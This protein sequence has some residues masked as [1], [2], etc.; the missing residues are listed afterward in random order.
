MAIVTDLLSILGVPESLVGHALVL[1]FSFAV[2]SGVLLWGR[3]EKYRDH[4]PEP[5]AAPSFVP[6]I[7]HFL[8]MRRH[9]LR[10]LELLR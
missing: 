4:V 10:Y 1:F 7:G 2:S 8:G 5:P 6:F 9:G 3:F